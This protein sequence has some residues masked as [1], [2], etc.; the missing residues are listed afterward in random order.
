MASVARVLTRSC[1]AGGS[2][3]R[4]CMGGACAAC[5]GCA[6][7]VALLAL[8]RW[9]V[10]TKPMGRCCCHLKMAGAALVL[11]AVAGA[12]AGGSSGLVGWG[13]SGGSVG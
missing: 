8:G 6:V 2:V 5:R 12:T 13:V 11:L 9:S 4:S 10:S 1:S 3:T 7:R